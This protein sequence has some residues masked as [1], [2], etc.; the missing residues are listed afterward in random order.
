M[1][2]AKELGEIG[3]GIACDTLRNNGYNILRRNYIFDHKEVDIIAEWE[4]K[5]VFVEVKTRISSFLTDPSLL[6][7]LGKQKQIIKVADQFVKDFYPEKEWRF[8]IMIVIT[9]ADYTSVEHIEDAFYPM[10]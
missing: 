2:N 1:I 10:V 6:V 8:D 9:N 3:E 5:L 7:S 4:D